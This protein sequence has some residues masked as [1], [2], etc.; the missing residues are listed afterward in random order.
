[1]DVAA[2][3][4]VVAD[5]PRKERRS[6]L[7]ALGIAEDIGLVR[8]LI[9]GAAAKFGEPD[10]LR[11]RHPI[12]R[13]AGF[14]PAGAVIVAVL[15]ALLQ[16]LRPEDPRLAIGAIGDGEAHLGNALGRSLVPGVSG[17]GIIEIESLS[18]ANVAL[19]I[20]EIIDRAPRL[21]I[22]MILAVAPI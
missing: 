18:A 2:L 1:L 15:P 6:G 16:R 13:R 11:F 8:A 21:I 4:E 19:E 10:R 12:R 5:K 14:D 3:H 7:G 20:V 9:D 17:G 22:E